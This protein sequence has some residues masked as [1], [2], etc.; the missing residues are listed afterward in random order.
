MLYTIAVL[1]FWSTAKTEGTGE[2]KSSKTVCLI[3]SQSNGQSQMAE[4]CGF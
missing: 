2:P 4:M 3:Y 1:G